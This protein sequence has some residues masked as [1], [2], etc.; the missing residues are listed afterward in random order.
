VAQSNWPLGRDPYRLPHRRHEFFRRSLSNGAER[1]I[2]AW[3]RPT[4]GRVIVFGIDRGGSLTAQI[5]IHADEASRVLAACAQVLREHVYGRRDL[6]KYPAGHLEVNVWI[7]TV[8]SRPCVFLGKTTLEGIHK[9]RP[10]VADGGDE[11]RA[12]EQ[13][14]LW[15]LEPEVSSPVS[16]R[17]VDHQ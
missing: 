6:G 10:M 2:F 3:D 12:L 13:A 8:E 7:R 9:G 15:L 4:Y 11:V 1:V 17:K 5:R 14:C 16:P